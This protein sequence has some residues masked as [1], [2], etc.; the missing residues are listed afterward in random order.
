MNVI[1]LDVDGVLNGLHYLINNRDDELGI[2]ES[3]MPLL[4][5]ICDE[6]NASIVLSSAWKT[7]W[8]DG[9]EPQSKG[10]IGLLNLFKKYN[11][12]FY[13]KTPTIEKKI[14]EFTYISTWKEY[15][16]ASYLKN[17]PEIKH[18]CIIDDCLDD[19]ESFKEY[20]VRT[21]EYL[22]DEDHEGLTEQHSSE[23]VR[24]MKKDRK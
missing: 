9:E 20:V 1:F 19:L 7:N 6:N 10:L 22:D 23:V 15:E 13:G 16:I 12:P 2:D 24:V 17:H 14:S 18:F 4:K 5:R 11:I 21:Y 8:L 3:K